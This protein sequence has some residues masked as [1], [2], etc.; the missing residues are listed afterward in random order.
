[1]ETFLLVIALFFSTG[2][3]LNCLRL[4]FSTSV[5]WGLLCL[6]LPPFWLPFYGFNWSRHRLQGTF[7][8]TS[9]VALVL[10]GALFIRANPFIFDGHSL[11]LVR[12]WVAPAFGQSPLEISRP[13]FASDYDIKRKRHDS[14]SSYGHYQGR[15][16]QFQQVVFF[17][18]IMRFKQM[19]R[20]EPVELVI[21]LSAYDLQTTGSLSLD[22]TPDTVNVP[23]IHVMQYHEGAALADV[24]SY[25]RGYWLELMVDRISDGRYDGQ[26]TLK[27][28]DGGKSYFAGVFSAAN[29]DLVWEFGQ[30]KR[31]YDS[32]HTIEYVAEQYLV[33]NLGSALDKVV[34]F[35]DTFFQTNLEDSTAHTHA[36]LAMVDG[37]THNLDI[38]LFKSEGGWV[39]ERSPV[40]DLISAL[41]TI[42]EEPPAAILPVPVLEQ[43]RTFSAEEVDELVGR[44]VMLVTWD[45]KTREGMLDAVDR[46]NVSIVTY[47]GGGEAAMLVKRREVKEVLLKD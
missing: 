19:D 42:R 16:L 14:K 21:D 36:T 43:P 45:G 23:L 37:S 30:V 2:L 17:D 22:I 25:D 26:V 13:M 35:D 27:L 47:I 40:R 11:A 41:Q 1:M 18:G 7:H 38:Q 29:R 39:V 32:N 8:L 9:L 5:I 46:Y 28:P 24:E 33:N 15:N 34:E 10:C 12:D 3:T 20:Q 4:A 31:S 6:F 44:N